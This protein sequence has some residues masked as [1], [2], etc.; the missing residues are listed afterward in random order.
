MVQ[1]AGSVVRIPALIMGKLSDWSVAQFSELLC[2]EDNMPPSGGSI[3]LTES[4]LVIYSYSCCFLCQVLCINDLV[5][6]PQQPIFLM[7]TMALPSALWINYVTFLLRILSLAVSSSLELPLQALT[8]LTSSCFRVSN[9]EIQFTITIQCNIMIAIEN[10][11]T[12]SLIT[13]LILIKV[14]NAI[15]DKN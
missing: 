15:K 10:D 13:R 5:Q 9:S 2:G 14:C 6:T 11:F 8:L 1:T 4:I 12:D 3:N 7:I